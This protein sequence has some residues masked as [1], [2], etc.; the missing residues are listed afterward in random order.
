MTERDVIPL[1]V[2]SGSGLNPSRYPTFDDH[3][4]VECHKCGQVV[5][6]F[7][8][9]YDGPRDVRNLALV[10]HKLPDAGAGDDRD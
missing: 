10:A 2:C 4:R 6:V 9:Y 8:R 3:Q 5:R 1:D 7:Q